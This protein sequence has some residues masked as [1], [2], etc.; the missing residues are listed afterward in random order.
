LLAIVA[1]SPFFALQ[2]HRR[3]KSSESIN[4]KN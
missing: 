4:L 2:F 1:I 3:K